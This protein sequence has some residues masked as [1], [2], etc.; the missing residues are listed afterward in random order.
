MPDPAP[1]STMRKSVDTNNVFMAGSDY[2]TLYLAPVAAADKL[3][4]L[5]LWT[6]VPAEFIPCGWLSDDGVTRG[7]SDK[8]KTVQGHQGHA[9][10]V[11]Y[12]DSSETT[13]QATVLEHKLALLKA[14]LSA[15]ASGKLQDTDGPAGNQDYV[16]LTAQYSRRIEHLCGIWDTFDTTHDGRK[17]RY[18]FPALDMSERDD[19]KDKS[20]DFSALSITLDVVA[21]YKA[22]TN[23][24]SMLPA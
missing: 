17:Y 20:G 14:V 8:K 19:A 13:L 11:T 22:L 2:D 1:I 15:S 21:D 3:K 10:V 4:T 9:V 23:L 5:K 7:M 18:I 16:E 24:P 12:M 6:P